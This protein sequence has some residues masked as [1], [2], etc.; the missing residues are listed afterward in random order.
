MTQPSEPVPYARTSF[1]H[2]IV[3]AAT[4]HVPTFEE[5][6][7]D[8][9]ANLQAVIVVL[10]VSLSSSFG[11]RHFGVSELLG[12]LTSR[13]FQW[14]L[15]SAITWAVGTKIFEGTA[16]FT[17]MVRVL[18]F[19]QAPGL[20]YLLGAI[21]ILGSFVFLAVSVWVLIAGVIAI[22][23]ALDVT[24]GKALAIVL[25]CAVVYAAAEVLR[26]LTV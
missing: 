16:D 13:T 19:V 8:R 25:A 26:A 17:E 11:L 14:L 5:I 7:H 9:G 18:G 15:I 2:R 21:P 10:L 23:Q 3:G 12:D 20:L 22:R 24:T 1:T 4:L 6:E